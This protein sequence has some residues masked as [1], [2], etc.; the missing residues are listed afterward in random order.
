MVIT[1]PR[2][3]RRRCLSHVTT[4]ITSKSTVGAKDFTGFRS[5]IA[6]LTGSLAKPEFPQKAQPRHDTMR[7]KTAS[8]CRDHALQQ[9]DCEPSHRGRPALE[10]GSAAPSAHI[11]IRSTSI[12][13][14][15]RDCIATPTGFPQAIVPR[16]HCI[17][18]HE[19]RPRSGRQRRGGQAG[20]FGEIDSRRDYKSCGGETRGMSDGSVPSIVILQRSAGGAQKRCSVCTENSA[21]VGSARALQASAEPGRSLG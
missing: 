5:T 12:R 1:H 14:Q 2:R 4:R 17:G 10:C 9:E 11:E 20:H 15:Q 19:G 6:S 21:T 7:W 3:A 16:S 8:D 13:H 18:A